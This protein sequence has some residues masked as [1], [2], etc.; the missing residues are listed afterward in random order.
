MKLALYVYETDPKVRHDLLRLT[1][2]IVHH[3]EGAYA[4]ILK[5]SHFP[6][7]ACAVRRSSPLVLGIK[8][9]SLEED[10]IRM[11]NTTRNLKLSTDTLNSPMSEGAFKLQ[12]HA[13]AEFFLV[14]RI[15][16]LFFMS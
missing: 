9:Q 11:I 4:L 14:C 6:G 2:K 5:S 10:V 13:S 7:E 16:S 12:P 15:P 8:A 1:L 3:L